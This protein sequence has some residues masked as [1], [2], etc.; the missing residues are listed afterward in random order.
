MAKSVHYCRCRVNLAG[1]NCHTVI[2]DE[3]SPLSWPE[4]Q[5]LIA[6]HGE[7][8]VMD[9][10]P[11]A[12]GEVWPS[13]EKNRL[14][15]I[16]GTRVVEACFPGRNFRMEYMMTDD[17]D[18]PWYGEHLMAPDTPGDDHDDGEDEDAAIKTTPAL[19]PIFKPGRNRPPAQKE[20]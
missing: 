17:T 3:F 4:V 20:A 6:L 10:M 1:Q 19:D 9:I 8:N 7:E 12:I 18:L 2:F 15:S 11:V 13:G 5:V 16:Y 14:A